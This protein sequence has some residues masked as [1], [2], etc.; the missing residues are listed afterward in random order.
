[1]SSVCQEA[2]EHR[3]HQLHYQRAAEERVRHLDDN[4]QALEALIAGDP[5]NTI[6]QQNRVLTIYGSMHVLLK[7]AYV[8]SREVVAQLFRRQSTWPDGH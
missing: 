3:R 8:D 6:D 4:C 1:M 7:L 2:A 5:K